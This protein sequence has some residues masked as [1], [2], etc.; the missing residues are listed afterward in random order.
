MNIPTTNRS[1]KYYEHASD[2]YLAMTPEFLSGSKLKPYLDQNI[3]SLLSFLQV[4]QEQFGAF[5]KD[6]AILETG[7]G[8]GGLCHHFSKLGYYT[9]GQDQSALA[10]SHAKEINKNLGLY[11]KFQTIDLCQ[12]SPTDKF[13]I[14]IDSHLL[15][16][17]VDQSDRESYLSYVLSSLKSGG[18][19]FVETMSYQPKIQVPVGYELDSKMNLYKE[20]GE[21]VIAYRKMCE[22]FELE[23]ELKDMGFKISYLYY[24]S[25]LAFDVYSDYPNFPVDHLP[26]TIRLV[27]SK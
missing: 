3:E 8:L 17:L 4:Y 10:V 11:S 27:A 2:S 24:H 21:S 15:H 14:V 6:S 22:S 13:D 26:K 12:S 5:D 16:C 1:K 7:C 23:K 9:V 19:F 25:E 18:K 20:H